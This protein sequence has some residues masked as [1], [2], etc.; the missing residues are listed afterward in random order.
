MSGGKLIVWMK[1]YLNL[2][3]F[4]ESENAKVLNEEDATEKSDVKSET[5]I[6]ADDIVTTTDSVPATSTP[7]TDDFVLKMLGIL[8]E[9][10]TVSEAVKSLNTKQVEFMYIQNIKILK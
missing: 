8:E 10:N 5:T 6:A 7:Q 9:L 2:F 1:S 4:V 3:Y